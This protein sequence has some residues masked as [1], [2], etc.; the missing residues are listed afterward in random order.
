MFPSLLPS[1]RQQQKWN[2]PFI[3]LS[4]LIIA[5]L[6]TVQTDARRSSSSLHF[7]S[8]LPSSLSRG[9]NVTGLLPV[10]PNATNS[11]F[12]TDGFQNDVEWDSFS[13][14]VK[15]QRFFLQYV[16]IPHVNYTRSY[17]PFSS[18]EFHTFRLPVPSMWLDILQKVK[19]TGMNT[20]S[21]YTH[22]SCL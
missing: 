9:T 1:E 13:L 12:K 20:I 18:G 14:V 8:R 17:S 2:W 3:A 5:A 6:S 11:P 15:G 4:C 22:C 16:F 7:R 21:V 10:Q 19:A